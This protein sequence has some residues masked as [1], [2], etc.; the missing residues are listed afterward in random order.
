[1]SV[2]GRQSR[3]TQEADDEGFSSLLEYGYS[4]FLHGD[5]VTGLSDDFV[6]L[7]DGS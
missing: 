5:I 6:Y 1:M 7:C 4:V 2:L 3:A